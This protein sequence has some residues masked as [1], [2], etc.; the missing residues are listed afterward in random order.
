M[1]LD[2]RNDQH[3]K[4]LVLVLGIGMKRVADPGKVETPSHKKILLML[5]NQR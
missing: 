2:D 5:I 1:G 3:K 4:I